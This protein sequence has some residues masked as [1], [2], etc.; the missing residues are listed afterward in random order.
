[1]LLSSLSKKR[2]VGVHPDLV[3]IVARAEEVATI[4]GVTFAVTEGLRTVERQKALVASG[5]SQ[6]MHSRHLHGFAVDLVTMVDFD[7]D[8]KL[9]DRYDWPLATKLA[10]IM[11][12]AARDVALPL[13]CGIDWVHF[14]DGPHFQLPKD[15]YPDPL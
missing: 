4:A 1:M 8:G 2:L 7:G 6:T 14:K 10:E 12:Q 9:E 13:Q 11:R 15:K 5:A 3:R